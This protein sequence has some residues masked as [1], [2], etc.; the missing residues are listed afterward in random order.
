MA[1]NIGKYQSAGNRSE[2][3]QIM[4]TINEENLT[5]EQVESLPRYLRRKYKKDA[6]KRKIGSKARIHGKDY[7]K[8]NKS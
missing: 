2:I 4:K 1:E 5:D 8:R 3:V 7:G 6:K